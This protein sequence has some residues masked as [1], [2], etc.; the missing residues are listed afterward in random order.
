MTRVHPLTLG[1][2]ADLPD[3][4]RRCLFWEMEPGDTTTAHAQCDPEFEKEA[5]I[6]S[7]TLSWG[8]CGQLL[9]DTTSGSSE[10]KVSGCALYAPPSSVPRAASFPTSPVSADAVL[11]TTLQVNEFALSQ[12]YHDTLL[13]AVIS[14][15]VRRGVRAIEAFGHEHDAAT[16]WRDQHMVHQRPGD[17]TP[18]TC[19]IPASLLRDSRFIEVAPH[20]EY[21]RFRYELDSDHGWKA[22][23]EAAL[24]RLIET[25][26]I[27]LPS[28]SPV[29]AG[30]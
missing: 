23:V 16:S 12:G 8:S 5:W 28:P 6:S 15:L 19:M 27:T 17:C 24:M 20:P 14:D 7:V 22:D 11:L 30:G 29:G 1:S 13:Q 10:E 4:A 9:Y 21:P 18:S 3:H 26:T 25:S 2:L